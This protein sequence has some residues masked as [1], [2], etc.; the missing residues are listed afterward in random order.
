MIIF[1]GNYNLPW[2]QLNFHIRDNYRLL[3]SNPVAFL[4]RLIFQILKLLCLQCSMNLADLYSSWLK[5]S[6]IKCSSTFKISKFSNFWHLKANSCRNW[7]RKTPISIL[8]SI[9]QVR[10]VLCI[11]KVHIWILKAELGRIWSE[12]WLYF[13]NSIELRVQ[14][15]IGWNFLLN[16]RNQCSENPLFRYFVLSRINFV[17]IWRGRIWIL[18]L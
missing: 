16:F 8:R 13:R 15:E 10:S 1:Q 11:L 9:F 12:I 6:D 14:V 3:T 4:I 17:R 2:T 5:T 7:L 18:Q